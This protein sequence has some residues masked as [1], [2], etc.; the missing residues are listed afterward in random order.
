MIFNEVFTGY[1]DL[2]SE[3]HGNNSIVVIDD[4]NNSPSTKDYEH[5]R[6]SIGK[7][8]SLVT[9]HPDIGFRVTK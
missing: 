4:Y 1:H 8:S 3:I 5:K 9:I 6:R 7:I 2:L